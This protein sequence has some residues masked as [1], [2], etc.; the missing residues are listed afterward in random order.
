MLP[1]RTFIQQSA[2]AL[3]AS[4]SL[5]EFARRAFGVH[6]HAEAS[7][8]F[9]DLGRPPDSVTAQT[10]DGDLH[11]T[12]GPNGTW[13]SKGI[14]LRT[15]HTPGALRVELAT[16]SVHIKR[17]GLRWRARLDDTR[18]ILGDAWERAY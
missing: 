12:A 10:A 18:A 14:Q 8:G 9:I 2:T 16:S 13:D 4:L 6:A 1:R 15:T 7:H 5:P 17:I 3:G 11:L